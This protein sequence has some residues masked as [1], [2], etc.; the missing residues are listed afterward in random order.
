[1]G[2]KISRIMC[3]LNGNCLHQLWCSIKVGWVHGTT[4]AEHELAMDHCTI[5]YVCRNVMIF[6]LET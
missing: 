6:W 1:M 2:S 4:F 5:L 3:L